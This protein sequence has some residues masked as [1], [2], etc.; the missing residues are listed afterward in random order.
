LEE[1][2]F[3]GRKLSADQFEL[4]INTLLLWHVFTR[5][6]V[7]ETLQRDCL[8]ES[9]SSL[10]IDFSNAY[11]KVFY[12]LGRV[13]DQDSFMN[14]ISETAKGYGLALEL[15][16]LGGKNVNLSIGYAYSPDST[17]HKSGT[18]YTGVS[19]TF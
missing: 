4:G 2:E 6:P 5:K 3:I 10:P 19:Y 16:Q 13:H 17:L 9:T 11:L 8:D 15:R 14:P 7:Q 12:D 1:G 18:I